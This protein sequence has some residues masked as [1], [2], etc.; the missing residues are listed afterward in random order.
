VWAV[1]VVLLRRA[2]PGRA[3][4]ADAAGIVAGGLLAGVLGVA[5]LAGTGAWPYF[6]DVFTRWNPEYMRTGVWDEI[7]AKTE[8]GFWYFRPWSLIHLVVLPLAGVDLW[9]ALGR[10]RGPAQAPAAARAV[11]AA[12]YL[13]WFAQALILQRGFDYVHV[14]ET[15]LAMAVLAARG[16]AVGFLYLM[17]FAAAGGLVALAAA[18]PGATRVVEEVN[19][20]NHYLRLEH[21]PLTDP[22]IVGLWSRCWREGSSPRLRDQLAQHANIHCTAGWE[23]LDAVARFL[24]PLA[25]PL[26][27]RELTCWHDS[28]HPLYLMLGI[29]PSTRYMHFGTVFT[30]RGKVAEVRTEVANSPQRYVV[31]DLRRITWN[32]DRANAPGTAGPHSYPAWLPKSQRRVFPWNQPVV[33]RS[34]RYVVH[35]VT[36]PPTA[37]EIDIPDWYHLDELGPGE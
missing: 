7:P 2:R 19:G 3:V 15:I 5:W 4:A 16:W 11:L 33:F 37:D 18:I 30:F 1:S 8:W 21:H 25:P 12:L 14:P 20:T 24:R 23:D 31:S 13:G 6:W 17:W 9:A 29:D 27:D 35:K 32:P 26:R 36:T 22:K 28:T 34:G 10:S